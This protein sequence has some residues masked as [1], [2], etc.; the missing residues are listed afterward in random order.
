MWV[1]G[2]GPVWEPLSRLLAFGISVPI[3]VARPQLIFTAFR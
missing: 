1:T 2:S 3:T